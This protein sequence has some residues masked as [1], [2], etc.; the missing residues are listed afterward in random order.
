MIIFIAKPGKIFKTILINRH[1]CTGK[2]NDK[3][4]FGAGQWLI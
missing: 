4:N 1:M 2:R 3:I